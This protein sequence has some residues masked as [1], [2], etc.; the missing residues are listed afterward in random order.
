M[1]GCFRPNW[2]S[3]WDFFFLL[4]LLLE[5]LVW[6]LAL[7]DWIWGQWV[8]W[9]CI[10]LS[11]DR[12][13]DAL[14]S[15]GYRAFVVLLNYHGLSRGS[16]ALQVHQRCQYLALA[17]RY[18]RIKWAGLRRCEIVPDVEPLLSAA[19]LP[20]LLL[21]QLRDE[22]EVLLLSRHRA[23]GKSVSNGVALMLLVWWAADCLL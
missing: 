23:V 18:I 9:L 3:R 5:N 7:L 13:Q 15:I 8:C 22:L 17:H 20:R 12:S 1:V 11:L 14:P 10:S 16:I 21:G 2:C 19:V 6:Q 4:P